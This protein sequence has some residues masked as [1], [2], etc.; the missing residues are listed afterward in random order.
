MGATDADQRILFGIRS[1]ILDR[2]K[3][4]L[5]RIR[6]N[7]LPGRARHLV[8][9]SG[10]HVLGDSEFYHQ[11]LIKT[12]TS[13]PFKPYDKPVHGCTTQAVLRGCSLEVYCPPGTEFADPC[14]DL[15]K[16]GDLSVYDESVDLGGELLR[17]HLHHLEMEDALM[18]YTLG[19]PPRISAS[20]SWSEIIREH[21][22]GF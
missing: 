7:I 14:R 12:V 9:I 5:V 15:D 19:H 21:Q 3:F 17:F 16:R 18:R 13:N 10:G 6:F 8:R 1:Q 11:L 2:L 20:R 4:D 22:R